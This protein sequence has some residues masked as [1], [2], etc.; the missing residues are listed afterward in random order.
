MVFSDK[1]NKNY[2]KDEKFAAYRTIASFQEYLLIDQDQSHLEH[3]IKTKPRQWLFTEYDD[4]QDSIFLS[5]IDLPIEL[6]DIY[7]KVD[8]S[9]IE[10]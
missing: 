6:T 9:I 5:S 3:Y 4:S 10:E 7:D 1:G 8:F 2:D